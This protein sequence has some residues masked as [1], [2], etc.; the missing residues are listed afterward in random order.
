MQVESMGFKAAHL[1]QNRIDG[2]CHLTTPFTV[3]YTSRIVGNTKLL[4]YINASVHKVSRKIKSYLTSMLTAV[5]LSCVLRMDSI[6]LHRAG[7]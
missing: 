2:G 7:Y 3:R 1:S 6:I 5:F 4:R